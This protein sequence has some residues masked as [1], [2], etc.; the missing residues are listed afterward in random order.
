[1]KGWRKPWPI[2]NRNWE[3]NP[4]L[5]Q[6]NELLT[7]LSDTT[8]LRILSLLQRNG[9]ICVCHMHLALDQ[10]QPTVSRH[11][12]RL[13]KAGLVAIRKEG[14]WIHYRID[15]QSKPLAAALLSTLSVALADNSEIKADSDRLNHVR[16]HLCQL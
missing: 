16:S 3:L 15:I 8:R 9:E 4:D 1:M 10:P 7:V 13:R 5:H 12:S 2:S 11:L 14:H 6:T